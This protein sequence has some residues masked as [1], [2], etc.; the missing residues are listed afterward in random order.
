MAEEKAPMPL[1]AV[2]GAV[3]L[4]VRVTPRASRNALAGLGRDAAGRSFVAIRLAAPPVDGAAN[5]AL[6][7]FLAREL[8]LGR[9]S[10]KIIAGETSRLKQ[11][12][13]E[14]TSEDAL[15]AWLEAVGN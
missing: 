14:G 10:L 8:G 7:T 13:I 3:I 11:V 1:R 15:A 5:T 6:V 4:S 9:S 12:R 2:D